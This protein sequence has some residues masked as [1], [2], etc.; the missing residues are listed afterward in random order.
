MRAANALTKLHRLIT[1]HP[2]N[3]YQ[4]FYNMA[5]LSSQYIIN[6]LYNDDSLIRTFANSDDPDD[7]SHNVTFHQG[8]HYLSRQK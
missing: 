2:L 3:K 6:P 4:R 5:H 7:M 8:L 1:I